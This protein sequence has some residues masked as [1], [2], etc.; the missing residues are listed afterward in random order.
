MSIQL[1]D[2][3][4]SNEDKA[5]IEA[6]LK[7]QPTD[8]IK[9]QEENPPNLSYGMLREG[10]ANEI[11]EACAS[12]ATARRIPLI[13]A[14]LAKESST[15]SQKFEVGATPKAPESVSVNVLA[16]VAGSIFRNHSIV[17]A[18][19][20]C[21]F[22]INTPHI[23]RSTSN[24][25]TSEKENEAPTSARK[26]QEG[27]LGSLR[28]VWRTMHFVP[29]DGSAKVG[30]KGSFE[31][32]SIA[33]VDANIL[34]VNCQP[35]QTPRSSFPPRFFAQ[36]LECYSRYA[37][38]LAFAEAIQR[39]NADILAELV[40]QYKRVEYQRWKPKKAVGKKRRRE[41]DAEEEG[42]LSFPPADLLLPSGDVAVL[43]MGANIMSA[44]FATVLPPNTTIYT[45]EIEPAVVA[46][47]IMHNDFPNS[48]VQC[49]T[50]AQ[51]RCIVDDVN[52]VVTQHL[53]PQSFAFVFLDCFDP[54][55]I[56]MMHAE[57]LLRNCKRLLNPDFG[58]LMVN[59]H[60]DC[61]I[62]ANLL[63]F[64]NVFP[65]NNGCTVQS[66]A[67]AG[68]A[69]SLVVCSVGPKESPVGLRHAGDYRSLCRIANDPNSKLIMNGLAL[70]G[71]ECDE[72]SACEAEDSRSLKS[73]ER[74][75][76]G[77]RLDATL[78]CSTQLVRLSSTAAVQQPEIA[79]RVVNEN[80]ADELL[81][82]RI[83]KTS[84]TSP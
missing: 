70:D 28:I 29:N 68:Y 14:A 35:L 56:T 71:W 60:K 80:D 53:T 16:C 74:L 49:A 2:L 65:S 47:N 17:L 20:T 46:V 66:I 75:G 13:A 54:L 6:F 84:D 73:T 32:Q 26:P 8:G 43:G 58:V 36:H 23:Q 31:I 24:A 77:G 42:E 44:Y 51:Q 12:L 4:L 63:P 22:P 61:N 38:H 45:A 27:L 59:C 55:A 25:K 39:R 11:R 34:Q 40:K 18:D 79:S 50:R 67:V 5:A 76:Q 82:A 69:Q 81:L 33:L 9:P 7:Q 21:S 62:H 1:T 19:S 48:E 57:Q 41:D 30:A 78:F 64:V 72:Q 83:W 37:I 15:E 10:V 3:R 52:V